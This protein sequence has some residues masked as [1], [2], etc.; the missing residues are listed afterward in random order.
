M[1]TPMRGPKP[2]VLCAHDWG[3]FVIEHKQRPDR[4]ISS[5]IADN[6]RATC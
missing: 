4:A 6:S 1:A 2:D 3:S 5:I